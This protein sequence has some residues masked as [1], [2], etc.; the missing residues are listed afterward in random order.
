MDLCD[1]TV[2]PTGTC[3]AGGGRYVLRLHIRSGVVVAVETDD[4]EPLCSF[5]TSPMEL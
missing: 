2:I 1:T 5:R 3:V 4:G